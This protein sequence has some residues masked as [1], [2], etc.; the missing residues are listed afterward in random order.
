MTTS[1]IITSTGWCGVPSG[2]VK[3]AARV[4]TPRIPAH[5]PTRLSRTRECPGTPSTRV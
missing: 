1:A 3:A 5:D 2:R 4:T